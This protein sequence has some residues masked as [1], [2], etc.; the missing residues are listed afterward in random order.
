[1]KFE[2]GHQKTGGRKK[3]ALNKRNLLVEEIASRFSVDPFE[4]LMM[5]VAADWK[6]LGLES[7][8]EIKVSDRLQA[9]KE[10]ARYLYAQKQ[11]VAVS[12]VDSGI[13][14]EI[15]DY[16]TKNAV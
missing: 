1:M 15:V 5:F 9:A 13:R 6:G 2:S 11:S 14:V 10:A 8:L 4:V 16:T 3:G 12:T 7:S